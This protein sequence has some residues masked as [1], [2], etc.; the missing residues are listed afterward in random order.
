MHNETLPFDREKNIAVEAV[1]TDNGR[2]FCGRETH[3]NELYL[4]LN[5]VAHRRTKVRTPKTNGFVERFNRTILDEFC[6]IAFRERVYDTIAALQD[7]DTWLQYY[8]CEQ[9][10]LGYCN[11]MDTVLAYLAQRQQT[12]VVHV[13]EKRAPVHDFLCCPVSHSETIWTVEARAGDKATSINSQ[14][15]TVYPYKISFLARLSY[16]LYLLHP[17]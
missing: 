2:E 7:M 10:H 12:A 17:I 5:D 13:P 4:D 11:P 15:A 9:P 8:N 3:P 1:L 6:H 14:G 16:R